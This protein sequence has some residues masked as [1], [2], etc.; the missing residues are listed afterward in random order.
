MACV[1]ATTDIYTAR[2][3]GRFFGPQVRMWALG[4]SLLSWFNWFF[5]TR[6][7]SNNIECL[8][9][10]IALYYWPWPGLDKGDGR[11]EKVGFRV[12]VMLAA[13]SIHMRPTAAIVWIYL[14]CTLLWHQ[15][16]IRSAIYLAL[17]AAWI[18][19]AL[20]VSNP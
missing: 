5:S 14:A 20:L 7:Y 4:A 19:Y 9:T 18:L 12:A 10:T 1:S 17:D 16:S 15:K 3:A 8:L 11:D 2:L 6:S 13:L